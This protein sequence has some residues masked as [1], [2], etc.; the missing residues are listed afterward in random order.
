MPP[1]PDVS[2]IER[3]PLERALEPAA[4]RLRDLIAQAAVGSVEL[5][6]PRARAA[7]TMIERHARAA[8]ADLDTLARSGGAVEISEQPGHPQTGGSGA[9]RGQ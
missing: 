4:A 1:R 9:S 2:G 5:A 6:D 7:L 3:L 8:L